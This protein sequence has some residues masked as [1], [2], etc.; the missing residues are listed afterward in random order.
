[1]T[2]AAEQIARNAQLQVTAA[3]YQAQQGLGSGPSEDTIERAARLRREADRASAAEAAF[4]R[5]YFASA[6]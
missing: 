4:L 2:V 3:Y 1:M 5:E 6:G